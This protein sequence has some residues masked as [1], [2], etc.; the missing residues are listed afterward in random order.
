M[1]IN[2]KNAA[3]IVGAAASDKT[4]RRVTFKR[5][6]YVS[7]LGRNS[8]I[9]ETQYVS[10]AD[11]RFLIAYK[12][13]VKAEDEPAPTAEATGITFTG[14]DNR[15]SSSSSQ[16]SNTGITFTGADLMEAESGTDSAEEPQR[17]FGR[18]RGRRRGGA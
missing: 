9:G 3:S 17:Y 14:A 7:S 8:A 11:A 2:T 16:V 5:Q 15:E 12:Y 18:G 13:A 10:D 4:K 1:P 6:T